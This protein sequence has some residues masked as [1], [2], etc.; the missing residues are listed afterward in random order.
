[1]AINLHRCIKYA[2]PFCSLL[3]IRVQSLQASSDKSFQLFK[4]LH[5]FPFSLDAFNK[6]SCMNKKKLFFPK[7]VKSYAALL[8]CHQLGQLL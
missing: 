5:F 6:I 8:F 2:I 7:N 1:M 3:S 4:S